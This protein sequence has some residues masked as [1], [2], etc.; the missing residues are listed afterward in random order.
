MGYTHYFKAK[1]S[2]DTNFKEFSDTC[3]KLYESLPERTNTAGGYYKDDK[4]EIA[5]SIGEGEPIFNNEIVCF[6]GKGE[7]SHE[8]F[9]VAKNG[10]DFEF[11]K[12]ARKPYDLLVVACLIAAWQ[13]LDYKFSSDGFNSDGTCDDLQPAIDFYNEVMQPK[14]KITG[15]PEPVTQAMLWEQRNKFRSKMLWGQRNKLSN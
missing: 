8:T 13:I 7:L 4:L 5:G 14:N 9:C 15:L 2:T 11:C 10:T 1:K 6:N 3:K 12:T